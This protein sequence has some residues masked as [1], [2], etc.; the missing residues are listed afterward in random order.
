MQLSVTLCRSDGRDGVLLFASGYVDGGPPVEV[1]E[2]IEHQIAAGVDSMVSAPQDLAI[3]KRVSR[4]KVRQTDNWAME[5]SGTTG[6]GS[7]GVDMEQ[8]DAPGDGGDDA[9]AST[10]AALGS[11]PVPP[12][13]LYSLISGPDGPSGAGA[14]MR[15]SPSTG[16]PPSPRSSP[17]LQPDGP[18]YL[19]D[20]NFRMPGLTVPPD[21]IIILQTTGRGS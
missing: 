16:P 15:T 3:D 5:D 2:Q 6:N 14:S 4:G 19:L 20:R 1:S 17:P 13:V 8:D 21:H 12:R 11:A 18:G 9:A 7:G 10:T